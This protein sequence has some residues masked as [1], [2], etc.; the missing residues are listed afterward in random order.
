MV[1]YTG[2]VH[3]NSTQHTIAIFRHLHDFVSLVLPTDMQ[4]E[5]QHALEHVESDPMLTRDDIEETMIVFGKRVWPYRKAL[6]EYIEL[7]EGTMGEQLLRAALPRAMKKRFDEFLMSGG[8]LRDLHSGVPAQFFSVEERTMLNHAFV[9]MHQSLRNHVLQKIKSIDKKLFE[10]KV[11]EFQEVFDH[12]EKELDTIRTMA[13]DNQEHPLIA[14]EMREHV[15]GFEHGLA[16][17][18]PEYERE[19]V[20]KASEHFDGRRRELAVRQI[21]IEI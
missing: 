9:D 6:Q 5:M 14:R 11:Q 19:W 12:L 18:G 8:T 21:T 4:A 17:L 20:G 15:R 7:Y 1:Y 3:S 13:D 2:M 10:E 16:M